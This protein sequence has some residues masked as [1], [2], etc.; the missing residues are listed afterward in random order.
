MQRFKE[1]NNS[2]FVLFSIQYLKKM[3]KILLLLLSIWGLACTN[4]QAQEKIDATKVEELVKVKDMQIVDLRTPA[5]L[6]QTGKIQGARH[7]NF[8]SPDFKTQISALEEAQPVIIYCAAGGRSGK[9]VQQMKDLGFKVI[10]DYSGGM[11]DWKAK[12]KPTVS[13]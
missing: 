2:L 1:R 12:G 13:N 5:E 7:I 10:Y 4:G 3:Q 11:S 6:Q 9:A 8:N